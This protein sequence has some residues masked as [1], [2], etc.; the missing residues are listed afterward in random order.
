[1]YLNQSETSKTH[2]NDEHYF[3]KLV[4]HLKFP[5]IMIPSS[6]RSETALLDLRQ[7]MGNHLNYVEIVVLHGKDPS[8]EEYKQLLKSYPEISFFVIDDKVPQRVGSARYVCKAISDAISDFQDQNFVLV[9]DDNVLH[10]DGITLINDPFPQFGEESRC[11]RSQRTHISL[12]S[13]MEHFSNNNLYD[14][15]TQFS[16]IG[17][18]IN[19]DKMENKKKHAYSRQHVFAAVILNLRKLKGIQYLKQMWAME[20][21]EFLNK[22][23][24]NSDPFPKES[25]LIV[26]C[27]RYVTVK[28]R[29]NHGGVVMSTDKKKDCL[30]LVCGPRKRRCEDNSTPSKKDQPTIREFYRPKKPYSLPVPE[31]NS[32]ATIPPENVKLEPERDALF[33]GNATEQSEYNEIVEDIKS[34][35]ESSSNDPNSI[36]SAMNENEHDRNRKEETIR[37]HFHQFHDSMEGLLKDLEK[38][39]KEKEKY[40]TENTYLKKQ[41]EEFHAENIRLKA[42]QE[43]DRIERERLWAEISRLKQ[44]ENER[45]QAI[46][47]LRAE[48]TRLMDDLERDKKER[49]EFFLRKE[50]EEITRLRTYY[51]K[52]LGRDPKTIGMSSAS[53]SGARSGVGCFPPTSPTSAT[54]SIPSSTGGIDPRV[55]NSVMAQTSKVIWTSSKGKSSK[56]GQSKSSSSSNANTNR[57]QVVAAAN[58]KTCTGFGLES[59]VPKVPQGMDK[60]MLQ[61]PVTDLTAHGTGPKT[62]AA[63]PS[64]LQTSSSAPAAASMMDPNILQMLAGL[65][66]KMLNEVTIT[67]ADTPNPQNK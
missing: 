21:V 7:Q 5:P 31:D 3:P 16:A 64:S 15:M 17:F 2:W 38:K 13:I 28:K 9:M 63:T 49:E 59:L 32:P 55:P 44:G 24:S 62:A 67:R 12:L 57:K 11:D 41:N 45:L 37:H 20:D 47:E 58:P 52:M 29:L 6:G 66:P 1:M 25:G 23:N 33:P 39:S 30:K 26:K 51:D 50:K 4:S 61:Y 27:K 43:R 42:D 19:Y 56:S 36:S 54:I 40:F 65:T 35:S 34:E 22:V 18:S 8:L 53:S 48:N 60:K 46:E 14:K 10:F